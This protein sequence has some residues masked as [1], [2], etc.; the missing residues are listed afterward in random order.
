MRVRR[1]LLNFL[2]ALSLLLSAACATLW[3]RSLGGSDFVSRGRIV[4]S[5]PQAVTSR[6]QQ[7][8]WVGGRFRF[9]DSDVTYYP[10]TYSVPP[11]PVDAKARWAWGHSDF[12]WDK[13]TRVGFYT[14]DRPGQSVW[15]RLGF[16]AGDG[17]GFA[18][19]WSDERVRM[20]TLPAWLPVVLFAAPAVLRLWPTL[21][22]RRR[23]RAN[24]CPAC[25]YDLRATPGR[26]PECG[27]VPADP[28]TDATQNP[29]S[30]PR[31]HAGA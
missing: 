28:T 15:N 4:R 17:P 30:P 20:L 14:A 23:R 8:A 6:V 27:R 19:S 3:V 29:G 13:L 26:C 12:W 22:A 9:T 16:Y 18:T 21:T 10:Q 25:G 24:L 1:R 5:S 7:L 31:P 2:T 11:P